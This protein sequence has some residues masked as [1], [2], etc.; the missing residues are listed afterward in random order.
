M[1]TALTGTVKAE[2]EPTTATRERILNFMVTTF[3]RNALLSV[4]GR[5]F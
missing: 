5:A 4:N 2:T 1:D 3:T